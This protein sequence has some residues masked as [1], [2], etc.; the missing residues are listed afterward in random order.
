MLIANWKQTITTTI[1]KREVGKYK[2]AY[3]DAGVNVGLHNRCSLVGDCATKPN[4][5]RCQNV[6]R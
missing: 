2:R 4:L 6:A 1:S 5:E 3:S